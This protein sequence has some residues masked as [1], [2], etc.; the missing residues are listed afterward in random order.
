M[1]YFME[2]GQLALTT[3]SVCDFVCWKPLGIH[4]ERIAADY[5]EN[6]K[7]KLKSISAIQTHPLALWYRFQPHTAYVKPFLTTFF[8]VTSNHVIIIFPSSTNAK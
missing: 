2:Q 8:I 1:A 5:F 4:I 7:I 6:I 3:T